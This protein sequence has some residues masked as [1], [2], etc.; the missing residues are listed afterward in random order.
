MRG[1]IAPAS[2]GRG[3][4]ATR[5]EGVEE[6]KRQRVLLGSEVQQPEDINDGKDKPAGAHGV[7]GAGVR[8][9]TGVGTDDGEDYGDGSEGGYLEAV[10]ADGVAREGIEDAED[11]EE[12]EED[13]EP[14][15]ADRGSLHYMGAC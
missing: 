12:L 5:A 1:R 6:V 8:E 9:D 11:E 7:L 4:E 14:E 13:G 10:H 15:D 3:A 2:A